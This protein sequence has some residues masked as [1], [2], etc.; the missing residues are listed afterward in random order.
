M[1]ARNA[2]ERERVTT[3]NPEIAWTKDAGRGLASP[4]VVSG[5]VV[6]AVTTNRMVMAFSAETGDLYWQHRK[7]GAFEVPPVVED[8]RL[9]VT[10]GD[11]EGRAYGLRIRDGRETWEET[12]PG[13][14]V[15]QATD[16]TL[17]FVASEV[18]RAFALRLSDGERVWETSTGSAAAAPIVVGDRLIVATTGDSLLAL[19]VETGRVDARVALPASV[20]AP[21]A[22][23]GRSLVLP[24]RSG[25]LL[26][27]DA[28]EL[29]ER[30]RVGLDGPV[31]AAPAIASTGEVFV[32]DRTASVWV[33]GAD[34]T[35]RRLVNLGGA[36][37]GSLTLVENALLVGLLDGRF[38]AVDRQMGRV[39]WTVDL[40][41]SVWAPAVV[42]DG[43]IFVPLRRGAVVKIR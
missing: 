11:L 40:G 26:A 17:L 6:L 28:S 37:R 18:G 35:P 38:M 36:A 19:D 31:L 43:S 2:F 4:P 20:S 25:E 30:W 5:Q 1:A 23:A 9:Y 8:D 16:G 12:V 3:S 10:T 39:L 33:V 22:L 27:L 15:P 14:A 41:D 32:L 24:L 21:P 29:E 13:T 34:G 7:H 42:Q